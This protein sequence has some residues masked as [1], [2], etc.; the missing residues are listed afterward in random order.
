MG[1]QTWNQDV[2][3]DLFSIDEVACINSIHLGCAADDNVL[4]WS[5]ESSGEYSVKSCYHLLQNHIYDEVGPL[6]GK[7]WAMI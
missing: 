2:L 5:F 3:R 6:E 4:M 1:S 7:M